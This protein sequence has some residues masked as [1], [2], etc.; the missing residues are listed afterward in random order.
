MFTHTKSKPESIEPM[1]SAERAEFKRRNEA[2]QH[3]YKVMEAKLAELEKLT[4]EYRKLRDD[5]FSR[6]YRIREAT[7]I[8]IYPDRALPGVLS[9]SEMQHAKTLLTLLELIKT[10]FNVSDS[11]KAD[12][13]LISATPFV[14]SFN[15][16]TFSAGLYRHEPE[17][18]YH[19]ALEY[20]KSLAGFKVEEDS[21]ART[22]QYAIAMDEAQCNKAIEGLTLKPDF[23]TDT[24]QV[25]ESTISL[26]PS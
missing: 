16:F 9:P 4:F 23:S 18:N 12:I 3:E 2:A 6:L 15:N 24:T 13:N 5:A 21:V 25:K 19:I 26:N 10:K 14:L 8:R 22:N 20:F 11:V 1:S 7:V 17:T